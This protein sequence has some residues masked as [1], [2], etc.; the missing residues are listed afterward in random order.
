M[1]KSS[2]TLACHTCQYLSLY[3]HT[4]TY[5]CILKGYIDSVIY[6]LY[7]E[8]YAN[9]GLN[10]L[11]QH[12]FTLL[13]ISL[14]SLVGLVCLLP[15]LSVFRQALLAKKQHITIPLTLKCNEKMFAVSW[16]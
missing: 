3:T 7:H 4:D 12:K 6:I 2:D 10:I 14:K 8:I 9:W 1:Q 5:I 15:E 16:L 11:V 13:L